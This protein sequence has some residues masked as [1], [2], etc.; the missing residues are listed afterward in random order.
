MRSHLSRREA[1]LLFVGCQLPAFGRIVP[2]TLEMLGY[3]IECVVAGI[4]DDWSV[5]ARGASAAI[6]EIGRG[7]LDRLAPLRDA[8]P[9]GPLFV[10]S[11]GYVDEVLDEALLEAERLD[12]T[13][14]TCLPTEI[15]GPL[16]LLGRLATGSGTLQREHT[17]HDGT[18]YLVVEIE[19]PIAS[20]AS[21]LPGAPTPAPS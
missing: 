11:A 15:R 20:R 1:G 19:R 7:G 2:R 9:H 17:E 12:V 5:A 10:M 3:E 21:R 8:M 13:A 6:V 4:D 16:D 14:W 18:H